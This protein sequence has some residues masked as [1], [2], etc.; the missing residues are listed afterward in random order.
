MTAYALSFG[1]SSSPNYRR[2]VALA[3]TLPG[4]ETDGSG[5]E[6]RHLVPL[7]HTHVDRLDELLGLV[8]GWRGTSLA[9]GGVVV[10]SAQLWTLRQVLACHRD[11]Q[12]SGLEGLYCWGL[13]GLERGRVPCR[14]LERL[15]PWDLTGDYADAELL[16]RLLV[17]QARAAMI[18][19]CPAFEAGAMSRAALKQLDR[20]RGLSGERERLER[21]LR[22]VDLGGDED[23]AD[24][25][26]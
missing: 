23:A 22:D 8:I 1:S 2:A 26:R 12:R 24:N 18:D 17:A 14:L 4:Y 16:P 21:L 25:T 7:T 13:P 6:I 11:R 20:L 9:A 19:G 10:G 5:R 15:L 3:Q